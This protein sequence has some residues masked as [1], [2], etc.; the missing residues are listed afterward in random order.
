MKGIRQENF[1]Q[2]ELEKLET[3]L[4][5]IPIVMKLVTR[6]AYVI[7]SAQKINFFIAVDLFLF[8]HLYSF[9]LFSFLSSTISMYI[10]LLLLS[11]LY[12]QFTLVCTIFFIYY[13]IFL[14]LL[15]YHKYKII[16]DKLII[17][18]LASFFENI[19]ASFSCYINFYF[20]ATFWVFLG[21]GY[22]K[23]SFL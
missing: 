2:I 17:N 9:Y 1:I 3:K 19:L 11:S 4:K 6:C 14:L 20:L 7:K 13:M 21:I 15:I 12:Y 22:N 18:N 5:W 23:I 16:K 10:S 8:S